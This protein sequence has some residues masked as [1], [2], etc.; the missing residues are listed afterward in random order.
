MNAL[1]LTPWTV[2]IIN[3]SMTPNLLLT[4]WTP[5]SLSSV[6]QSKIIGL[7]CKKKTNEHQFWKESKNIL[8][9]GV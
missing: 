9:F 7:L 6:I 2:V 1:D 3:I 8:K 5:I 4:N